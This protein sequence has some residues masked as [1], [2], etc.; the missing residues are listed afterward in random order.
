MEQWLVEGH[1]HRLKLLKGQMYG[2][3]G[4]DLLKL[5]VLHPAYFLPT[6]NCRNLIHAIHQKCARTRIA[7]QATTQKIHLSSPHHSRL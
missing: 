7:S 4:F 1:T 6:G 5:R 2:G 3:A